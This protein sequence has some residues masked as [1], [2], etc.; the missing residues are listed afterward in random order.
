MDV[1]I[2]IG[3]LKSLRKFR[4]ISLTA[5]ATQGTSHTNRSG[6]CKHGVVQKLYSESFKHLNAYF[7]CSL[8]HKVDPFN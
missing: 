6:K 4:S 1:Y 8:S 2:D 7:Q 3:E 5:N